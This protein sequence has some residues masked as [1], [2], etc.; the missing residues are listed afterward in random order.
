MIEIIE[1]K[2][3]WDSFVSSFKES[4]VY[5]TFD[6][7]HITKCN[8]KPI[9]IRY[10]DGAACIGLPL[11][12]RKIPDTPFYDA[13]SVYGYPG[14]LYKNISEGF[15]NTLFSKEIREYFTENNIV[16]VFSRLNPFIPFQ[17][18]LLKG[19]GQINKKG[20]VVNIDLKKPIEQQRME[21]GRR[22]KGQLNKVRRHCIVK[23]AE[24]DEDLQSFVEIYR[25]NMDRVNANSMYY[26][27]DEYFKVLTESNS[28]HTE[29]LLALHK[30]S[31][32]TIGGSMFIYK[33]S[34]VHY[35]LSGTR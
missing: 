19:I 30:D 2:K 29:T 21:F 3:H 9:L 8:D 35:H 12:I 23:K 34:L 16:S 31:G 24:N 10:C 1:E 5:H 20:V 18:E 7:H 17:R 11:L 25:E 13:T 28:F 32:E 15:D 4:D 26:F 27:D 6:Y 33:N 22:L 14:P